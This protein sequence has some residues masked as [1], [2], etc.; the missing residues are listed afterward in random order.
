METPPNGLWIETSD[1]QAE[2]RLKNEAERLRMLEK[3]PWLKNIEQAIKILTWLRELPN[4]A[5][6]HV[7]G[8]DTWSNDYPPLVDAMRFVANQNNSR[9]RLHE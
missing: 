4:K 9:K 1:D 8:S 6:M 7:S 5:I 3:Q 2:Q